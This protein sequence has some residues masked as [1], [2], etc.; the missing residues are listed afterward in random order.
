MQI[1]FEEYFNNKIC[2]RLRYN[3]ITQ[4]KQNLLYVNEKFPLSYLVNKI[5]PILYKKHET[6]WFPF[7]LKPGRWSHRLR[8]KFWKKYE[9]LFVFNEADTVF[10][11]KNTF[12]EKST[13][14]ILQ[15]RSDMTLK[16]FTWIQETVRL[17]FYL[18]FFIC[19]IIFFFPP[20][21]EDK[22]IYYVLLFLN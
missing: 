9:K 8:K 14:Q 4:K 6:R 2:F 17:Y 19:S 18:N 21:T 15:S 12:S 13:A 7:L 1:I 20:K 10:K 11:M 3:K 5:D 22:K 16:I